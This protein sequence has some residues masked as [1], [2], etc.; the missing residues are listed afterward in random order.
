MYINGVN[1]L[2]I[3]DKE[4]NIHKIRVQYGNE[5]IHRGNRRR[6]KNCLLI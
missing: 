3:A 2:D 1:T 5:Q 6:P 4:N